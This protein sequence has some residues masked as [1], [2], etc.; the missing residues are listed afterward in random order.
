MARVE[1]GRGGAP[2]LLCPPGGQRSQPLVAERGRTQGRVEGV[3]E[4]EIC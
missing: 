2:L 4:T 1:L 3:S